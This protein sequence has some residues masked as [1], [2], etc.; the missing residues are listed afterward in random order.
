MNCC[1]RIPETHIVG[2]D[3]MKRKT[4]SENGEFPEKRNR[5]NG[6]GSCSPSSPTQTRVS[7]GYQLL[8]L[9]VARAAKFQQF[10][11]W[12]R[13]T[14]HLNTESR[15]R[16]R[17]TSSQ[18]VWDLSLAGG[19]AQMLSLK[20]QLKLI[21]THVSN[22]RSAIILPKRENVC[23][24]GFQMILSILSILQCVGCLSK[25]GKFVNLISVNY[26]INFILQQMVCLV[27]LG[28]EC[29]NYTLG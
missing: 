16:K 6:T 24:T 17:W 7:P 4:T 20:L 26:W 23:N 19:V 3:K 21:I 27:E 11:T 14:C 25:V 22:Q 28:N 12:P 13:V 15:G 9:H 2:R 1:L 8:H 10:I 18:K 5:S 29:L